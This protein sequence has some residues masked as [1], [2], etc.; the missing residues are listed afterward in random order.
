MRNG[1]ILSLVAGFMCLTT[2]VAYAQTNKTDD[3]GRKQGEWI[4]KKAD[5][6]TSKGTYKDGIPEG[7]FT[8]YNKK[9]VL[10]R[11]NTYSDKGRKM[12][13]ELLYKDG[14]I[15]AKGN[16]I[17]KKKEGVWIYHNQKGIKITEENYKNGLKNGKETNWDNDG[18]NIVMSAEYK[19]GKKNG[20][21]FKSLYAE[22]Y[23]TAYYKDDLL[24]GEYNEY[25]FDKKLK[26]KGQFENG[27]KQ[28]MWLVYD[29][30]GSVIQKLFYKDDVFTSDAI[31]FNVQQGTREISQFDIALLRQAG[32]QTQIILFNG[33]RINCFNEFQS[34]VDL[35][36]ANKFVRINEKNKVYANIDA[37]QGMNN[38]GSVKLKIDADL[39][40]MPDKDGA[41]MLKS[42]FRND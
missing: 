21:F 4:T 18:K 39:N 26:V 28:G 2:T 12:H 31:I 30:S 41:E 5:G 27:L 15:K 7:E 17:N 24:D 23:Y 13:C 25:G 10:E 20:E 8:Y 9:G 22:G 14:K 29:Q 37:L 3:K 11:R 16:Y 34:I 33:D 36:D 35:T 32:K 38:D 42:M 19:D 1:L 6:T 40:I